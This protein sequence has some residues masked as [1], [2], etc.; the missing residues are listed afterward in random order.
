LE[1]DLEEVTP[2]SGITSWSYHTFGWRPWCPLDVGCGAS[3]TPLPKAISCYNSVLN[4]VVQ[5]SIIPRAT[6]T[7][8]H[9]GTIQPLVLYIITDLWTEG[10]NKLGEQGTGLVLMAVFAQGPI[11]LE[12]VGPQHAWPRTVHGLGLEFCKLLCQ[13]ILGCIAGPQASHEE[14]VQLFPKKFSRARLAG[15]R[16]FVEV[17]ELGA[18]KLGLHKIPRLRV[19]Q[20]SVSLL[21]VIW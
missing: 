2:A 21:L 11:D 13:S 16:T 5:G 15:G 19:S 9:D 12:H 7:Y 17:G 14:V 18:S 6:F 4:G 20:A 1:T 3:N 10:L 8:R